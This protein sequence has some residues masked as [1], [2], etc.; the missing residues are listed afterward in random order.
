[1][2]RQSLSV[3]L[4]AQLACIW[5]ATARKPGNVCREH[6]TEE[7][8]YLDL[9]NSAAAV[10]PVL[11]LAHQEGWEVGK[12]VLQTVRATRQVA[13]TN[14][15]LGILLLLA[16]L[17]K[18]RGGN[19]RSG[20]NPVLAGL[21]L[22]DSRNVYTAIRLA[23]PGGLGRVNQQDIRKQPT[24]P[25]REIMA[26]AAGRDQI[27]AQYV[28][29]F[30]AVFTEG[31][32]ALGQGLKQ[33]ESMEGA[34]VFCYLHLLAR[35]PDSLIARKHGHNAAREISLL[36]R[37]VLKAGWPKTKAGCNKLRDLAFR[38]NADVR[39]CNPGTTADLVTASLF[40]LLRQ[41]TIEL[42]LRIPFEA[43]RLYE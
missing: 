4:C 25:L 2:K 14:T 29:G 34:I 19:L 42:P 16:P 11:E 35:H 9:L 38:F 40:V 7:L 41:G 12:T 32:P 5:E 13:A 36:A 1:M 3:G 26:L 28:N 17:V 31:L 15:N 23:A 21:T 22:E 8:T 27:A 30:Q 37:Q 10:A 33:C 20:L 18:V 39:R 6:D 43:G 24:R